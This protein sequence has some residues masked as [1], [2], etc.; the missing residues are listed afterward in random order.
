MTTE[1]DVLIAKV[2]DFEINPTNILSLEELK[3]TVSERTSGGNPIN[4][5]EHH[6]LFERIIEKIDQ[7]KVNFSIGPIYSANGGDRQ[8]PG[9]TRLPYLEE[10][11]GKMALQAT[12]LRRI[13]GTIRLMDS[14]DKESQ[15]ML[16]ISYHQKGIQVAY[17]QNISVCQNM[18]IFGADNVMSTYAFGVNQSK[19]N[20]VTK[21]IEVIGDWMQT[22]SE[23]RYRDLGIIDRMKGIPVDYHKVSEIIGDMTV[24]RVEKDILHTR[25]NYAL[26]QA[27]IS[28]FTEKYIR[29]ERENPESIQSLWD[30]YNL[31]TGFHKAGA[32]DLPAI[33]PNNVSLSEYFMDKYQLA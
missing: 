3:Q 19:I 5:V 15:G 20:N 25:Q 32:T 17:G 2:L 1:P 28:S 27:Q 26:N 11:Y 21:M 33:I 29:S 9:V 10:Q 14:G 7:S 4:G 31:G 16:A 24:M 12:L 23:K 30:V 6:E 18:S 8:F 13:I 22:H